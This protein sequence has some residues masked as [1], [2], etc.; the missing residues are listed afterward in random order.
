MTDNPQPGA[1]GQTLLQDSAYLSEIRPDMLKFATLQ[2]SDSHQAEDAV[3]EAFIGALKNADSFANKAA[4]KTWVFAILK[5]KIADILRFRQKQDE[6][7][8]KSDD[9]EGNFDDLFNQRGHWHKQ[10]RPGKWG[11][12]ES[13]FQ[14]GQFWQIFDAC[15]NHLPDKQ[16]RIFAMREFIG[17][18][19]EE[20]CKE[21][22]LSTTNVNVILHRARMGLRQCLDKNWFGKA[23]TLC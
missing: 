21:T 14:Q 16:S 1:K 15:L 5:Y 23:E 7:L 13:A 19:S 8:V 9:E 6:H 2:L 18:S 4:L 22:E 3:Q 20:I 10:S 17:L 11:D 12:P